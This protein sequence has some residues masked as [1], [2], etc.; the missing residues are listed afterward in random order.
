MPVATCGPH[1]L[2]DYCSTG[3]P[4]THSPP[5]PGGLASGYSY[6]KANS[7]R[8]AAIAGGL[9]LAYLYAG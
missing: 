3:P 1:A 4:L 5:S 6:A 9:S 2:H 7:P 8:A